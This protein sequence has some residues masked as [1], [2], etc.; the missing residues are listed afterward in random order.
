MELL[1]AGSNPVAS[2]ISPENDAAPS[3]GFPETSQ[4]FEYLRCRLHGR[5]IIVVRR[6]AQHEDR[7]L[8]QQLRSLTKGGGRRCELFRGK[9]LAQLMLF[10][11]N[12]NLD[13]HV[14]HQELHV[15]PDV[16]LGRRV[17]QQIGRVIGTQDLRTAVFRELAAQTSDGRGRSQQ[18]LGS[19]GSQADNVVGI[20]RLD[21]L[22]E[23]LATV[24]GFV[25][26]R[27]PVA[28]WA[29]A[30]DI[31]DVDFGTLKP[32]GLEDLVQQL[33]RPSDEGFALPILIGAGSFAEKQNGRLRISDSENGLSASRRQFRASSAFGNLI[34]QDTELFLTFRCGFC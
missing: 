2:W 22:I 31:A 11:P 24:C 20:H 10:A 1:Q 9:Q 25:G 27:V 23:V 30:E 19:H 14:A 3:I 32:T 4:L 28:G 15:L 13:A 18:S 12:L 16:L 34:G 5:R 6:E 29:T 7:E 21:L 33:P 17:P 8:L 26:G